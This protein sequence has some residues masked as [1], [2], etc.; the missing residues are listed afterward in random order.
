MTFVLCSWLVAMESSYRCVVC[1]RCQFSTIHSYLA[2]V[3]IRHACDS[4]FRI[5]CGISNCRATYDKYNSFSKHIFRKH[6]ELFGRIGEQS[7]GTP[8]VACLDG[9]YQDDDA[10]DGYPIATPEPPDIKQLQESMCNTMADSFLKYSLKLREKYLLPASTHAEIIQDCQT[11]MMGVLTC[12]NNLLE[13]CLESKGY[14]VR[15]DV[16]LKGVIDTK[17]Y[18]RLLSDSG[19]SYKLL[20]NCSSKMGMIEPQEHQIDCYKGYYISLTKVLQ[21]LVQ[22]EDIA[23]YVLRHFD[24]DNTNMTGF[25]SGDAFMSLV[26]LK[27]DGN[28]LIIH[29]YNDEFEVVNPIGARRGKQKIN[30]TYF[31]L[32]NLP[33]KFRSA[34]HHIYLTFLVRH[35]AVKENG[36]A[37]AFSPLVQELEKLYAEGFTVTLPN[38]QVQ[39]FYAILCTVSGDNLSSHALAGFRTVFSSG[40]VCRTCMISYSELSE[41]VSESDVTLR[42]AANHAYHVEAVMENKDNAAIYGVVGPSVFSSLEYFNVITSFP[43]D[44]MHDC[45]EKVIPTLAE[46]IIKRLVQN[47][48]ITVLQFNKNMSSFRFKGHDATNK[49]EPIKPDCSIV[50]SAAQKMCLFKLLPFFV[51]L[52]KCTACLQLYSIVHEVMMYVFSRC[53]SRTDL[54]YFEQKIT[55]LLKYLKDEFLEVKISPKF[56]YLLHYP[57]MMARYGPLREL[58]CMRYEAKHQ[59]FKSL[60]TSVGNF[61]NIAFTLSSRH[62]M[63]QCYYFSGKEVLTQ[64]TVLPESGNLVSFTR[65]PIEVQ[66]LLC[67]AASRIWS[68]KMAVAA[69]CAFSVGAAVVID[70]TDVGDPVFLKISHLLIPHEGHVEIVGKLLMTVSFSKKY[71]AYE[72]KDEGWAHCHPGDVKDCA[73]LWPYEIHSATY[74]SVSYYVPSWSHL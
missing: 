17:K 72:V 19:S 2:H 60:A 37:I 54:D 14:P 21:M 71:C 41:K 64:D 7:S 55:S 43:P 61:I 11:M 3:R 52:D 42:C 13:N 36:Y 8:S 18:E 51:E 22:K 45:M 23:P 62:Q 49:P 35:K 32:G 57:S 50:G 40:R 59:Y 26:D 68:V 67:F 24:S 58:W 15:D 66:R 56:H 69:G 29:L 46:V 6:S 74:I 39:K 25:A 10:D 70:F 5:T 12:H 9:Y 16:D 28:L 4:N 31:S 63:Q 47:A 44:I 38:G 48:V 33:S 73:L 30:A 20:R 1:N 65:L 53:I 34:L 27:V